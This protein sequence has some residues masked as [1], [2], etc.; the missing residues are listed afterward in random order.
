PDGETWSEWSR[1]RS[2]P[3]ATLPPEEGEHVLFAQF[4]NGPGLKSPVVS[5]SIIVDRTPPEVS[6]PT[7][8]LR[9]APIGGGAASIPVAVRWDARDTAAG[10]SDASILIDCGEN[11]TDRS[12]A[13]GTADPGEMVTWDAEAMLFG[14]ATCAVTAI[15]RDGAGNMARSTIDGVTTPYTAGDR[16]TVAGDQVGVIARR[17]PDAGR[18]AVLL[19]GEA[20]GLV[21]LFAPEP[22]GPEVVFVTDLPPG[23]HGI[24]IEA[25]GNADPASTGTTVS[26]DGFIT[27]A[28]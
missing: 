17:G 22:S 20:L 4:R 10:L 19:D 26:V 16:A 5:D 2:T 14:G 6:A 27:L 11:L 12:E 28:G 15:S 7:V 9:L 21:D 1:I 18:A 13:P 24:E 3:T 8:S 23:S 25:T